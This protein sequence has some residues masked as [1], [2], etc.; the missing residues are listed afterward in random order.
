MSEPDPAQRV[1]VA[2]PRCGDVIPA[3]SMATVGLEIERH[4]AETCTATGR[5]A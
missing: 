1:T 4:R 3:A 5:A 2:C